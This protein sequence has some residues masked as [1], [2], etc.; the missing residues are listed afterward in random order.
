MASNSF[1]RELQCNCVV[2]NLCY[3]KINT[4][5]STAIKFY[6]VTFCWHFQGV[7]PYFSSSLLQLSL[8][9]EAFSVMLPSRSLSVDTRGQFVF[10]AWWAHNARTQ[11]ISTDRPDLGMFSFCLSQTPHIM[12]LIIPLWKRINFSN[13]V[14]LVRSNA[15]NGTYRIRSHICMYNLQGS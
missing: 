6:T 15:R 2:S 13:I 1:S 7:L 14:S 12:N 9:F 4:S 5:F 10:T 11:S 8:C 3:L